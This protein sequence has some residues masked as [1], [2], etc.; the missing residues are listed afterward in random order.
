MERKKLE[1]MTPPDPTNTQAFSE[2]MHKMQSATAGRSNRMV[3][4]VLQPE[5][6]GSP[7]VYVLEERQISKKSYP[8]K[9]VVLYQD[10]A[11][12]KPG[13]RLSWM[14][15]PD[16]A[17]KM[18]QAISLA[19]EQEELARK[20]EDAARKKRETALEELVKKKDEEQKKTFKKGQEDLEK[21]LGF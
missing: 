12:R 21:E 2:Y 16:D 7:T 5:L 4:D 13:Y 20:K 3:F 17:I 1:E 18:A 14:T 8:T 11:L 10:Q 15:V 6:F 19:E 9:Y